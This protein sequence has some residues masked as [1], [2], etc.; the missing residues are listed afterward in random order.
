MM[1]MIKKAWN[2]VKGLYTATTVTAEEGIEVRGTANSTMSVR[3]TDH[4]KEYAEQQRI[5]AMAKL[6]NEQQ[7]KLAKR[8][9]EE[10]VRSWREN[11]SAVDKYFQKRKVERRQHLRVVKASVTTA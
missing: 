10:S 9:D 5:I 8:T 6:Y 11:N 2:W 4:W 3:G 1:N 7:D